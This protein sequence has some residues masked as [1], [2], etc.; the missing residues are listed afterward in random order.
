M[1]RR[2]THHIGGH[3]VARGDADANINSNLNE[4][5]HRVEIN[6]AHHRSLSHSN[7][8]NVVATVLA[9]CRHRSTVGYRV[10]AVTLWRGRRGLVSP[11]TTQVLVV[12]DMSHR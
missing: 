12:G 5:A 1:A 3:G 8:S 9:S 7:H 10:V 6:R 11:P 2:G 4:S